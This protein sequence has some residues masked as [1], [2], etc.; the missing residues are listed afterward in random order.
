[1][2]GGVGNMQGSLA[3]YA[4]VDARLISRKP[5]GLSFREAAALPLAF[6][7]AYSGVVDRARLAAG[8]T[9]LVHGGAGGVGSVAV[10]LA[11]ARG[12]HVFSTVSAKDFEV[13]RRLGATP[14]DYRAKTVAE[15]VAEH[16]QGRGFDLVV[17]NVGGGTLDASF[18]A[19]KHFGHVVS[20]L[21]WGTHALAPLSFREA[22]YSGVFTLHPLLTGEGREHVG[23][24]LREAC[25]LVD[26]GKLKP[27]VDDRVFQLDAA[28]VEAAYE[29][30]ATG[31]ARGKVVVSVG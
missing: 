14:I 24:T 19:V 22:T 1:M 26:R 7:T 12:G 10:Q 4:A 2:T 31:A 17:D 6:V 25:E 13:V 21:G 9:V 30:V 15:Y 28:S 11:A 27:L 18:A 8:S 23:E 3:E 16:T 5:A 29:L 20:A